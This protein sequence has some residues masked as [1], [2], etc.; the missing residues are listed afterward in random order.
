M[1]L[2]Q[3]TTYPE[4]ATTSLIIDSAGAESLSL[5]IRYPGWARSGVK[6]Q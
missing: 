1:K 4:D 3:Q 5:Y 2:R 6:L